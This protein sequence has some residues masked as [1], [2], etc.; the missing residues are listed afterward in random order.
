MA[1]QRS[2]VKAGL[3]IVICFI[4]FWVMLFTIGDIG[5]Y[6]RPKHHYILSCRQ[7]GGLEHNAPVQYAGFEAGRVIDITYEKPSGLID[8]QERGEV[9][10][11]EGEPSP[12]LWVHVELR[13][14][15]QLTQTDVAT[16]RSGFTGNVYVDILPG[17]GEKSLPEGGILPAEPRTM[18]DLVDQGA[19][20]AKKLDQMMPRVSEA[21]ER[22]NSLVTQAD[23]MM[24]AVK[25]TVERTRSAVST[26]DKLVQDNRPNVDK[27][28][29]NVTDATEQIKKLAEEA[30]PK[31]S[32][33][34]Q[35]LRQLAVN[36]GKAL[37]ELKPKV[38]ASADNV[39]Q[40]TA[41]ARQRMLGN[42]ER[43][44]QIIEN[45]RDASARL[46]LGMEDIR[47]NPWKLLSRNINADP[48][49]QNI[50]DAALAF[51]DAAR[52]LAQA[53]SDLKTM[54]QTGNVDRKTVED[55][56]RE[57]GKLVE[58]LGEI[59]NEFYRSLKE[60]VGP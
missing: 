2:E 30:R 18:N 57:V 24:P 5:N 14:G 52:S 58:N 22:A 17:H 9:K 39:Q 59:E 40:V 25:D 6:F 13:H 37:E 20:I 31:I 28:I 53:S 60:H 35:E 12:N 34:V 23:D 51:S 45:F 29:Q 32:E 38:M 21:V 49:T 11:L 15:I 48:Q 16:I 41:D 43:L 4:L 3:M 36:A 1:K 50:Y 7:V 56:G 54:A 26:L 46:N 8:G 44:D 33:A 10:R 42:R 27:S 47:R 55:A 19:G